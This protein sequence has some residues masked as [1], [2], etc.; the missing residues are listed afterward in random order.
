MELKEE[1]QS[2]DHFMI[3]LAE[4][5]KEIKCIE[6]SLLGNDVPEDYLL[7]AC[8]GVADW[9]WYADSY[10]TAADVLVMA[11][12]NRQ[13]HRDQFVYPIVALYRQSIELQL[14]RFYSLIS[15]GN[16]PL[17]THDLTKI[18]ERVRQQW[19]Q[20]HKPVY[21]SQRLATLNKRLKEF[22]QLD[23]TSQSFR[24]PITTEGKPSLNQTT[25]NL[26]RVKDV[27]NG[28]YMF[29]DQVAT[30]IEESCTNSTASDL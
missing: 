30:D 11:I 23:S 3:M 22:H 27:A 10:K 2:T 8:V 16:Q 4:Y 28:I 6:Q 17:R 13:G 14:K 26:R 1:R 15:P 25:V 29:I 12:Q 9:A 5:L 18:W 7:T 19:S 21:Y 24:Y 20:H